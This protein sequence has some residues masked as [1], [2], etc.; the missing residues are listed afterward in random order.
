MTEA[1]LWTPDPARVAATQVMDFLAAANRTDSTV[2]IADASRQ[3]GDELIRS[4]H[5]IVLDPVLVGGGMSHDDR[6]SAS[7]TSSTADSSF[8]LERIEASRQLFQ[9]DG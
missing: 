8:G 9:S 4:G 1:P 2:A 6:G 7:W 3:L 5:R